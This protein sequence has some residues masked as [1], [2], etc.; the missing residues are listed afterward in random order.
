MLPYTMDAPKPLLSVDCNE[1]KCGAA[2]RYLVPNFA[3]DRRCSASRAYYGPPRNGLHIAIE[4]AGVLAGVGPSTR[5][6]H[7]ESFRLCL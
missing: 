5:A 6:P 7:A 1:Q 3:F 2:I 4:F